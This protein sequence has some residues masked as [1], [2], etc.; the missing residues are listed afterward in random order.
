MDPQ[1]VLSALN[2]GRV[3]AESDTRFENCFIGTDM[4]RQILLPQH[5]LVLGSKGSGKSAAFRLFCTDK[6]KLRQLFPKGYDD[7]FPIPGYGLYNEEYIY[8]NEFRDI[9]SD[10]V[11]DFRYFWLMV[12][13]LKTVTFIADEPKIRE[14]VSKS[15]NPKVK[16]SFKI[17]LQVVDDLG[18]VNEKRTLGKLKQRVMQLVK[19]SLR[20]Q[21]LGGDAIP[22]I[23]A[24]DFKHKTGTSVTSVLDHIDIVLQGINT[25]AWIMLDKLDL[26]FIDDFEKLKSS[27][28]GLV[29]LLIEQSNR[30][31][32]IHFKIFLRSDI[33]RQLRIVNKSHLVSYSSEM[34]WTEPLLLKLLVS[35]AVAEEVVRE[36]C[37]EQTGES[38]S[39]SEVIEGTDDDVLRLFYVLFESTINEE[40][41]PDGIEPFV[42]AWMLSHLS[43]GRGHVYPREQI[44]L[45]NLAVEKQLEINRKE[46]EH[47]SARLISAA[48]LKEALAALS[49][50]RCDTYLY[51]EFPH[52]S[53]HFDTF[54]GSAKVNFT[55]DELNKLFENL[56]PNGD[57]GIR[58][59]YDTGLL[60]PLG[61][62]VDSSMEFSI[63]LLYRIGLGIAE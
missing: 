26:L 63:P 6:E 53:K 12:V 9:R 16:E 37:E 20:D 14:M 61:R 13:G 33:Y 43:D 56:T 29:Q 57:E 41:T 62:T 10:S 45:G 58:S 52:L 32:N 7:V 54:R 39:I 31:K 44:H 40:N 2:F 34:K 5:S 22:K 38:V 59:V 1:K 36:Y 49:I 51:S 24:G 3:D 17:I 60:A 4:L 23:L 27:I 21:P 55:R 8:G 28:T 50:Y 48:A 42:H 19:P 30:F 35:R 18:L 25:L 46:R 47:Q 11:D 15:K